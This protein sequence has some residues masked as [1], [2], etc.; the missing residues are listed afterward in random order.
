M[1]DVKIDTDALG[2][3]IAKGISEAKPKNRYKTIGEYARDEAKGRKKLTRP[4]FQNGMPITERVLTNTEIDLA[5]RV[6]HSGRYIDR[7]VEAV[8]MAN[9]VGEVEGIDFRYSNRT[10]DQR[11]ENKNYWRNFEDML[12]QIVTAQEAEAAKEQARQSA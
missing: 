12:Q 1:A 3:A 7:R 9:Q 4:V 5:N 8:V 2:S 6:K 11:S 10:P